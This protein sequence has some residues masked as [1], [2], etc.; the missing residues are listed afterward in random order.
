MIE[1]FIFRIRE[2]TREAIRECFNVFRKK[3]WYD[4]RQNR[5]IG[6]WVGGFIQSNIFRSRGDETNRINMVRSPRCP[7]ESDGLR[8]MYLYM[9]ET[10]NMY[11][12]TRFWYYI[13]FYRKQK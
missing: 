4:T 5:I 3:N 9:N 13:I 11:I 1:L 6:G 8:G 10:I 7:E 2:D 12:H